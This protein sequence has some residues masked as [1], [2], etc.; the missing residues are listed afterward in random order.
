M[1]KWLSSC[2][3][4]EPEVRDALKDLRGKIREYEDAAQP[5]ACRET[6]GGFRSSEIDL[7]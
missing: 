6:K 2:V 1:A 5:S 3:E 4:K 7:F